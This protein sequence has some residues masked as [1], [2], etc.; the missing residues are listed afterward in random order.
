VG[1]KLFP[2][3]VK[4]SA[5]CK[6]ALDFLRCLLVLT[7][8]SSTRLRRRSDWRGHIS[9]RHRCHCSSCR[10]SCTATDPRWPYWC[11]RCQ[12]VAHS[13]KCIAQRVTDSQRHSL[14]LAKSARKVRSL[15]RQSRYRELG[16]RVTPNVHPIYFKSTLDHFMFSLNCGRATTHWVF[17][18]LE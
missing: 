17:S 3:H 9:R 11:N 7:C 4:S 5:I 6:Y 1:S 13:S 15:E 2:E 18:V 8:L 14:R 10:R 12:L 16:A